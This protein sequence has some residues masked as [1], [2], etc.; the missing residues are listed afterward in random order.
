M[1]LGHLFV[2]LAVLGTALPILP[3]A[4]FILLA[5][6]CYSKGSK[7]FENWLLS[8]PHIGPMVHEW[9]NH[10]VIRKPPL[11]LAT[12][13]ILAGSVFPMYV[14][15]LPHWVRAVY[16]IVICAVIGFLW[17]LPNEVPD[18]SSID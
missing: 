17:T 9:R 12:G 3:T 5:A 10:R 15:D 2:G 11:W 8:R 14:V 7:R 16:L 4:P 18:P 1:T 6:A 13:S